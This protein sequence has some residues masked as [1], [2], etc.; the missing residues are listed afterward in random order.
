VSGSFSPGSGRV[1]FQSEKAA[2]FQIVE[3]LEDKV[4]LLQSA[5]SKRG[6]LRR[7]S[8]VIPA[9]NEEKNIESTIARVRNSLNNECEI[10]VVDDGS[11]DHTSKLAQNSGAIVLR[12]SR[13]VGKGACFRAGSKLVSGDITVQI[14]A[15]C[16]FK[17]EEIPQ[18]VEA[19]LRGQ[20]DVVLAT[21]FGEGAYIEKGAM[22]ARNRIGNHVASLITSLASGRRVTD[23]QAG[24]KAFRTAC[25]R[26]VDFKE[27]RFGYEPEVVILAAWSGF[28]IAEVPIRYEKRRR[29][30]SN[31]DFVAD[32]LNIVTAVIRATA[33]C[34]F[35]RRR[36]YSLSW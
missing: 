32:A 35:G 3:N 28:K 23:I 12:T 31:I 30:Q 26:Q 19:I 33:R 29:G 1:F 14:D 10:I 34:V 24:F 9:F 18:L 27:N 11:R 5:T 25:L 2:S 7:I 6:L 22:S 8:V 15:D 4:S 16:Q 20:A 17:P 13:N 36:V 21:R